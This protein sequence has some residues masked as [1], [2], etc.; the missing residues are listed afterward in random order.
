MVLKLTEVIPA[1]RPNAKEALEDCWMYNT[2]IQNEQTTRE[3][4]LNLIKS[5]Y[6]SPYKAGISRE[7][8]SRVYNKN[9]STQLAY[10]NCPNI[11]S[12]NIRTI[13]SIDCSCANSLL[14]SLRTADP[15]IKPKAEALPVILTVKD[16]SSASTSVSKN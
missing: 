10:N 15:V 7:L 9:N 14:A 6:I 2:D 8:M 13:N 1:D 11:N 5:P 12:H 4:A 3:S 16:C